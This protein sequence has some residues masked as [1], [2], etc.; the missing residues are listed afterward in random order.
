[1]VLDLEGFDGAVASA[2]DCATFRLFKSNQKPIFQDNLLIAYNRWALTIE[3]P[4][5]DPKHNHPCP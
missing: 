2:T 5:P 3:L 4:F 1:M